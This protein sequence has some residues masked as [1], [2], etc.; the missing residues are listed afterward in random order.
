MV[1]D[2]KN[3]L[4]TIALQKPEWVKNFIDLMQY[5][6][7]YQWATNVLAWVFSFWMHQWE[8][9]QFREVH[10]DIANL[11]DAWFRV[12]GRC[13]QR[14]DENHTPY[15]DV[16][17]VQIIFNPARQIKKDLQHHDHG[18][19][20]IWAQTSSIDRQQM[21]ASERAWRK[22]ERAAHQFEREQKKT[23]RE[24]RRNRREPEEVSTEGSDD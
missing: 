23:E 6:S 18:E 14:Y 2:I 1:D 11:L 16:S 17:N 22:E 9:R 20:E 5:G 8:A 15:L 13:I 12:K 7:E 21:R 4:S 3:S 24:E 19:D 10:P